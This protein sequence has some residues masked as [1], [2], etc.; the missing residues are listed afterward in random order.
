MLHERTEELRDYFIEGE[1]VACFSTPEEMADKVEYYLKHEN[2]RERLRLA[3]HRR[4]VAE[5][6][7]VRRAMRIVEHYRERFQDGFIPAVSN[8]DSRPTV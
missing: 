5:N 2:E 4:C 6:S 1:E 8:Q 3:G 7:L